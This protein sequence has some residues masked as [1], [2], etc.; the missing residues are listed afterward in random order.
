MPVA[1]PLARA[2]RDRLP[3]AGDPVLLRRPRP[4]RRDAL[5]ARAARAASLRVGGRL[6]RRPL[7]VPSV[8]LLGA[9]PCAR[10]LRRGTPAWEGGGGARADR[11]GAA[12][13][14]RLAAQAA[15]RPAGWDAGGG[16]RSLARAVDAPGGARARP[17]AG[18]GELGE[19]PSRSRRLP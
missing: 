8:A 13:A 1:R 16:R 12:G 18:R 17:S 9:D 15:R 10:R 2:A 19:R 14:P 3:D 11:G 7:R 6:S 4:P 5:R